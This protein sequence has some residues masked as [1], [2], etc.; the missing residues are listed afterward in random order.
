MTPQQKQIIEMLADRK[1]H[2]PTVELYLKDDRKRISELNK[3]N[4][5][6]IGDKYCEDPYHRHMSKVKL[7]KLLLTPE[8]D[9][10]LTLI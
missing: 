8:E 10:Q 9:H 5:V 1:Y 7:R 4:Y 3:M 6:I 2:C